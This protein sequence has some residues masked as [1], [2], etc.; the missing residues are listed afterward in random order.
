MRVAIQRSRKYAPGDRPRLRLRLVQRHQPLR[1]EPLERLRRKRRIEEHVDEDIE[2]G[3]EV[4]RR[5]DEADRAAFA[6]DRNVDAGAEQLQRIRQRL[7]VAC[8]RRLAEH[9]R[10]QSRDAAPI[11]SL[12]LIGS[13]KERDGER[14]QRQVVLLRDDEVGAVRQRAL[15]PDGHMKRRQFPGRRNFAAV[16]LLLLRRRGDGC[17]E[18]S[19]TDVECALHGCLYALCPEPLA[20]TP[21]LVLTVPRTCAVR[22]SRC[23]FRRASRPG[24]HGPPARRSESPGR[25]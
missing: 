4:G 25:S 18:D 23:G 6:R 13:S 8:V 17:D 9:R 14:H 10:R 11:G 2:R 12:E 3:G 1:A 19:D 5:A 20:L 15:R 22:P 7:A 24:R 16:E 21:A